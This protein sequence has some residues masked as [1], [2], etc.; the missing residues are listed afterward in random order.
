MVGS[1]EDISTKAVIS[2]LLSEF[3][4]CRGFKDPLDTGH[5]PINMVLVSILH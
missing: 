4:Y 5:G 1:L 2:T 3:D